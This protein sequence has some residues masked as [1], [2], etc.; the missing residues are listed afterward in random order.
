[1]QLRF[2][3]QTYSASNAKVA[4]VASEQTASFKG[5]KYQI[6]VPLQ[7]AKSR[8]NT[9]KRK[10]RGVTYTVKSQGYS[11]KADKLAAGC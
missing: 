4:T 10:Y 6:R 1:M 7:T 3:G 11:T 8:L 2:M 5:Q 9:E